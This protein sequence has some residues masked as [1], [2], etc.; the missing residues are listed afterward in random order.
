MDARPRATNA[1]A[2][3]RYLREPRVQVDDFNA[4]L[5]AAATLEVP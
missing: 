4:S 1:S 5:D 2:M 3:A